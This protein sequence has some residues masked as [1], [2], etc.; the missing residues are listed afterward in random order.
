MGDNNSLFAL[1]IWASSTSFTQ[2]MFWSMEKQVK[3]IDKEEQKQRHSEKFQSV[4]KKSFKEN[5]EI[6]AYTFIYLFL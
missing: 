1:P 6:S 4:K 5:S 2:I 3:Q